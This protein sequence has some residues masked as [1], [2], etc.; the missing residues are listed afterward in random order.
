MRVE[1]TSRR[2][3][4]VATS[5]RVLRV[6]RVLLVLPVL[7]GAVVGPGWQPRASAEAVTL[8]YAGRMGDAEL[9][10]Y[11]QLIDEFMRRHPGIRV[12]I[13]NHPANEYDNRILVE[14]AGGTGPDVMYIHYSRFPQ[15]ANQHRPVLQPP[16]LR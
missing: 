2:P 15:Y 12:E 5:L 14:L 11:R 9:E 1:R 8:R 10:I 4:R 6:L 13:E 7:L 3:S 16:P